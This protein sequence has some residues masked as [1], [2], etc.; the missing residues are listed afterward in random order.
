MTADALNKQWDY[1]DQCGA[2][3]VS[4]GQEGLPP[5]P[6]QGDR[7]VK[8]HKPAGDSGVYQKLNR[9]MTSDNWPGGTGG[10]SNL[11]TRSPED[12][13]ARYIVYQYIPSAQFHLNP[14]HGW[15]I[16]N[17]FKENYLN[18]G[19]I[20]R[21]D[22]IWVVGCNN[23]GPSP[24][25][26]CMLSPH[27]SPTFS[28]SDVADRWTKWEYR[29]YQGERDT[30][31]HGGRIELYVDDKLMD[32]GYNSEMHV[33]SAAFSPWSSTL[34]WVWIAGQYTSNQTTN[35]VPDYQNTD[36]TSYVGLSTVLPLP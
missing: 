33:G 19:G 35:G 23:F 16:L 26:S 24:G 31:G 36:V 22:P 10:G 8:W 5:T 3:L 6:W 4:V 12:V 32:V 18:P 34:G 30:T 13:S 27:T 2:E 1:W 7:V 11:K 14:G 17:G 29:L 9:T 20:W 15:V 25:I 28:F 21:Q